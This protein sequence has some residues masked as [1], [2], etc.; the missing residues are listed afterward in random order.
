MFI[1]QKEAC[2][3]LNF[4][5]ILSVN[6]SKDACIFHRITMLD[7]N[8]S[9]DVR[10]FQHIP[11]AKCSFIRG[12]LPFLAYSS[13]C[14]VSIYQRMLIFFQLFT[15]SSVHLLKRN[16]LFLNLSLMP[17][18]YYQRMPYFSI[19]PHAQFRFVKGCQYFFSLSLMLAV[20]LLEDTRIIDLF[21]A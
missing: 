10:I 18:V 20:H 19:Y 1:Y 5:L 2:L 8:L 14:Q 21:R 13:P 4:S 17:R 12:S 7:V 6:L 9:K 15:I 3:F 16:C 11:H